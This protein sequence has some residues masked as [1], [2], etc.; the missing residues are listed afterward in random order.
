M[1]IAILMHGIAG[2]SD[3]F[4]TG[5]ELPVNLSHKHFMKHILDANKDHDVD[6]FMHS[7]SVDREKELLELYEPKR[8]KIEPQIIFDFEYTVGNPDVEGGDFNRADFGHYYGKYKGTDNLRFHSMFSK[9]YSAKKANS[10]K[11]S[12]ETQNGF[13]YD[14]VFLTRYDLAYITDI[15]F[16]DYNKEKFYVIGPD[17]ANGYNDLFFFSDSG[18]MNVFCNLFNVVKEIKHFPH[19][20]IGNHFLSKQ[21]IRE[22][23]LINNVEFNFERPWHSNQTRKEYDQGIPVGPAPPIRRWY[24]LEESTNAEAMQ[25]VRDHIHD[26][27]KKRI[28]LDGS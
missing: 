9:W 14:F 3:K 4:G 5:K 24:D 23:G 6:V 21:W 18:K 12:Y 8:H 15:K 7:W 13:K 2:T 1:K 22:S 10:L 20:H 26:V 27:S 25:E 16:S 11:E 28:I 17:S 19:K